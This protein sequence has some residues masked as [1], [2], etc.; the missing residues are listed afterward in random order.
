MS[1]DPLH[2]NPLEQMF[3][4]MLRFENAERYAQQSAATVAG[5]RAELPNRAPLRTFSE[6][7][8][9]S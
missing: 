4:A 2:L 8:F 5:Q 7:V 1:A 3:D 9:G 6:Q